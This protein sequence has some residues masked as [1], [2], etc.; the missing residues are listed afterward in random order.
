M[1]NETQIKCFHDLL[2]RKLCILM[3]KKL[4]ILLFIL[5]LIKIFN[6]HIDVSNDSARELVSLI[7]LTF[8]LLGAWIAG[9]AITDGREMIKNNKSELAKYDALFGQASLVTEV[10]IFNRIIASSVFFT[11]ALAMMFIFNYF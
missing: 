1:N 9:A 4:G 3:Y 7:I 11:I 5:L 6:I 10:G 8:S 2:G